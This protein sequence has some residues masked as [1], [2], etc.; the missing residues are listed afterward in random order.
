M[1]QKLA[2]GDLSYSIFELLIM[3]PYWVSTHKEFLALGSSLNIWKDCYTVGVNQT[4]PLL[5]TPRS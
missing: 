5:E 2:D 1:L 4:K 3:I